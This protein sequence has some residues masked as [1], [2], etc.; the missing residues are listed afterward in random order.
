MNNLIANNNLID[1]VRTR[2][3]VRIKTNVQK[4]Q[5]QYRDEYPM[6][7]E[8]QKVYKYCCPICLRYFNTILVSSCC[9]NYMCRLCIGDMA[10]KA[11]KDANFIIRCPHCLENEFK[12]NDVKQE[13]KLK[14]YTDT[15]FK[16]SK[17]N[18]ND[19][20]DDS[21]EKGQAKTQQKDSNDKNHSS[22]G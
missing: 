18:R 15:P 7:T 19:R 14:F 8:E 20:T 13:D 1:E 17:T 2:N 21:I 12:L 4:N 3:K 6:L 22:N 9:A 11:K 5:V 16:F 10:K